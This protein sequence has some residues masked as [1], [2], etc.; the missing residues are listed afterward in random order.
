MPTAIDLSASPPRVAIGLPSLLGIGFVYWLVFLLSLEPDNVARALRAGAGLE[1]PRETVRIL[2]A[3]LLGCAATPLLWEQVRRFPIQGPSWR[4]HAVVQG[5]GASAMAV[6]LVA[7]SCFLAKGLLIGERRPLGLALREELVANGPLVAFCI[8]A[9]VA[10][11]HAVRFFQ[12]AQAAPVQPPP[13][14]EYISTIRV[15]ERGGETWLDVKRIDWVETQG[16]YIA[17]HAGGVSHLVRRSLSDLEAGLDPGAFVRIHRR[18]LVAFDRIEAMA[19]VGAG[20]A[21]LRLKDG[22]KLRLSRTYRRNLDAALARAE[23][24][25]S[26]QRQGGGG[27]ARQGVQHHQDDQDHR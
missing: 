2:G 5:L 6:G 11:A 14:V 9:F 8:A 26:V 4:R 27:G 23:R 18:T 16:N 21:E 3:S 24:P 20:D 17:L 15:R 25:G 12:E 13:P 7:V 19:P 1:W 22:V 10:L